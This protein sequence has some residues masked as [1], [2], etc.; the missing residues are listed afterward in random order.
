MIIV[1]ADMSALNFT[2]SFVCLMGVF[3]QQDLF[4]IR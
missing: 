4:A 2:E 1:L 3:T